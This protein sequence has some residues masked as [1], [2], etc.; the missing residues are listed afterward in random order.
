[1]DLRESLRKAKDLKGSLRKAKDTLKGRVTSLFE[2]PKEGQ[3][4]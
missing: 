1:M 4:A 2:G 3:A